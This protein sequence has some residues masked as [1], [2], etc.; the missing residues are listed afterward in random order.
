MFQRVLVPLDG[1]SR[2]EQALPVAV[3]IARASGGA[4]VLLRVVNLSTEFEAYSSA[5]P[6]AIQA[7]AD[8]II[9]EARDY[10]Q[11]KAGSS[12]LA[13]VQT[14]TEAISGQAA[15]A[16]LSAVDT[17]H[18]DLIVMCSH[19]YTGM[20]RWTVGSV[21]EK[22]A[23]RSPVP[24]LMLREGGPT[25]AN[26]HPPGRRSLRALVPLDG[27]AQA[28]TAIVPAAQL[29]AALSAP[30]Q[31]IL[32]LTQVVI[33]PVAE[34]ISYSEREAIL[35]GTREYLSSTVE[36]IRGGSIAG[37]VAD[38]KLSLTWSVTI[39]DDIAAG[40][41][42]VAESGGDAEGTEKFGPCDVIAMAT[43]G[44]SDSQQWVMGSI[45][46]RVLQA[47]RLPL[48]IVRPPKIE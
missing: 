7:T 46:D 5:G 36:A 6:G 25:L 42:R 23:H 26:Q 14:E 30:E 35:Q 34:H 19:G 13:G 29:I 31:G 15:A 27:S 18:I 16:I 37:S 24:V 44:Y 12:N 41:I 10:L 47:T 33:L 28:I 4:V 9:E 20:I 3:R 48:L 45:T 11:G 40:I 17:H 22:V 2:A 38:L 32:H 39:D 8:A 1:S 43:H 21:A